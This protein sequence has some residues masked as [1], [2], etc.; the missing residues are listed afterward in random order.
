MEAVIQSLF[1][2]SLLDVSGHFDT[3]RARHGGCQLSSMPLLRLQQTLASNVQI[4][5]LVE[6]DA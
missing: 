6:L 5:G 3:R 1:S 4:A 2:A